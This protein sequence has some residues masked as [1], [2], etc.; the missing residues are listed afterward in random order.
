MALRQQSMPGDDMDDSL[1]T[2]SVQRQ[3]DVHHG[4]AGTDQQYR[5]RG[6]QVIERIRSPDLTNISPTS[7]ESAVGNRRI[8]GWEMAWRQH[9]PVGL[10]GLTVP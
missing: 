9:D 10:H 4:Q 7:V 2:L 6:R 8:T 3:H 1:M 5:V